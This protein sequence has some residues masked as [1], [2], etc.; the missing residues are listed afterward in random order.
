MQAIFEFFE[1]ATGA[2]E[3]D[4]ELADEWYGDEATNMANFV[5]EWKA[6]QENAGIALTKI[7]PSGYDSGDEAASFNVGGVSGTTWQD[8][9]TAAQYDEIKEAIE[10][11]KQAEDTLE[12]RGVLN[13]ARLK[14]EGTIPADPERPPIDAHVPGSFAIFEE[15]EK[16]EEEDLYA[17]ERARRAE[18]RRQREIDEEV[19]G[20]RAPGVH[21]ITPPVRY[22]RNERL[23]RLLNEQ[24]FNEE[25]AKRNAKYAAAAGAL[26][27]AGYAGWKKRLAHGESPEK[28]RKTPKKKPK[29]KQKRKK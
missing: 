19:Y 17:M 29:T 16:E 13:L 7:K 12:K 21:L 22:T 23:N 26:G 1:L 4:G 28:P 27:A 9:M 14:Y 11:A 3:T 20:G 24:I 18:E 15:E 8:E 5:E 2:Q 6:K 25:A 10:R